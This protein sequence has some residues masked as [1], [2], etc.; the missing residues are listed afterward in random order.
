M[1]W[2]IEG[3]FYAVSGGFIVLAIVWHV[4][5]VYAVRQAIVVNVIT[6]NY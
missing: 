1:V 3:A 2:Q 4:I 6:I 5:A